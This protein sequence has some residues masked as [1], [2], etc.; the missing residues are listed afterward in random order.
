MV[1]PGR[2]PS[3]GGPSLVG[4]GGGEGCVLVEDVD[5]GP[6][7]RG[8]VVLRTA[9]ATAPVD[10]AIAR[11][12]DAQLGFHCDDRPAVLNAESAADAWRR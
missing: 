12:A 7:W 9:A 5:P 1:L 11:Y 3:G 8:G 6:R 4:H 2:C 10:T